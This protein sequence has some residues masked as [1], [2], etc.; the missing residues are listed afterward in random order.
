MCCH[1]TQTCCFY[2]C[3][4]ADFYLGVEIVADATVPQ[5]K[6]AFDDGRDDLD[7]SILHKVKSSKER[8]HTTFTESTSLGV[9]KKPRKSK[10][11]EPQD[12]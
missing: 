9:S 4:N 5:E 1:L 12:Y 10:S 8:K 2:H 11:S 7:N 3:S 6:S